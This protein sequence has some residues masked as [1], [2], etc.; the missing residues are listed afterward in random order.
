MR[1]MANR[2]IVLAVVSIALFVV[3]IDATV[4]YVALPALTEAMR[5]TAVETL[6]IV[7]IYALVIAS[8]LLATG[9]IGDRIGRQR[10]LI[11]GFAMF[12]LASAVVA[13]ADNPAVLIGGRALLGVGGAMIMPPTLALI[14]QVFTVPKERTLAIGIWSAVFSVGAAVGP[15]IAGLLLEHFWWGS[16]FLINV[17]IM[18]VAIPIGWW[19]LPDSK[20]PNPGPWDVMSVVLSLV[21]IIGTVYA[22]KKIG[23]YGPLSPKVL[24]P[25]LAGVALLTWFVRRQLRL[26]QPMLDVRLLADRRFGTAALCAMIAMFGLAGVEMFI[27]QHFQYI[28]GDSPLEAG[29]RLLPATVMS[30]IVGPGAAFVIHRI[31]VRI[32]SSTGFVVAGVGLALFA[33]QARDP[34]AIWIGVS[35]GMLGAGAALALTAASDT[36]MA[37]APKEKAGAAAA[38]D[39]TSYEIGIG[40][41]V[42]VL[43]SSL[44]HLFANRLGAVDGVDGGVMSRAQESVGEALHEAG[45]VGGATGAALRQ[46]A[47]DA[48]AE[49]LQLTVIISAA[50]LLLTGAVAAYF[51]PSKAEF[52]VSEASKDAE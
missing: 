18:A 47:L 10:M 21:G 40:L 31:G 25:G 23:D 3:A 34:H 7:D 41:G 22:L 37:V 24:L 2:W 19:L 15:L 51:F 17:P 6:W 42:A 27:A 38:V 52:T 29:A 11:A 39:E 36:I 14:R 45:E 50:V 16:V 48:F 9:T 4:L 49:S 33:W 5:P 35:M 20:D 28:I 30:I 1:G 13:F 44:A 8:V 26:P 12:G 32:T 46:A 43:G